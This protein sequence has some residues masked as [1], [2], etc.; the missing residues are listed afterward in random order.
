LG[1]AEARDSGALLL[2][3]LVRIV[4][5]RPILSMLHQSLLLALLLAEKAVAPSN[6]VATGV[7]ALML[8]L[9]L[10][11][12]HWLHWLLVLVVQIP[13]LQLLSFS[14]L[15]HVLLPV[16]KVAVPVNVVDAGLSVVLL[17]HV[18][19]LLLGDALDDL[20]A[21]RPLRLGLVLHFWME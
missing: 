1:A 8:L 13:V 21:L 19:L 15:E 16:E 20:V 3:L 9:L 17:L 4:L 10:L 5:A 7:S 2:V 18:L 11:L 14:V 6:V 12:L